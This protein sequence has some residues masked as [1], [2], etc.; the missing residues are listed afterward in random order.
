MTDS[1]CRR[2]AANIAA[3]LPPGLQDAMRVLQYSADLV[4]FMSGQTDTIEDRGHFCQKL[5][6]CEANQQA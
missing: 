5:R 6:G 2:R 1:D 3:Q 4:R